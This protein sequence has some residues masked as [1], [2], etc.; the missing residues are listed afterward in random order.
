MASYLLSS[1]LNALL[2]R[3]FLYSKRLIWMKIHLNVT[4]RAS[5]SAIQLH[6]DFYSMKSVYSHLT[7]L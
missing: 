1:L 7:S 5:Y 2:A 4:A 6:F 3:L